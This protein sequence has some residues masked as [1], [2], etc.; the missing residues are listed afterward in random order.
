MSRVTRPGGVVVAEFYNPWSVRGL[1]KRLGCRMGGSRPTPRGARF[2]PLTTH[3]APYAGSCRQRLRIERTR[4]V[5]IATPTARVMRLPG[6]RKLFR[7]RRVAA[8]RFP[9]ARFRRFLPGCDAKTRLTRR[10]RL[11]ARRLVARDAAPARRAHA[12]RK[13]RARPSRSSVRT[14]PSG[15]RRSSSSTPHFAPKSPAC[16][17]RTSFRTRSSA[18]D[19]ELSEVLRL[20]G[21][22]EGWHRE[23]L[24]Q[25]SVVHR[26][27]RATDGPVTRHVLSPVRA[28]QAHGNH[29]AHELDV[30]D[31]R[32]HHLSARA[33]AGAITLRPGRCSRS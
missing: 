3:R 13:A 22:E 10:S 27:Q 7:Q 29:R 4:G 23:L 31:D 24:E 14:T 15:W 21:N 18:T 19:P 20:Y 11:P 32:R 28:C 8:V 16:A 1:V 25:V 6:V 17:R 5:R 30:R 2:H 9:A 33:R 26:W 12:R